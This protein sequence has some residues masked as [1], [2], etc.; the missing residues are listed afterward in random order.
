MVADIKFLFYKEIKQNIQK[1]KI[2]IFLR[3]VA[4]IFLTFLL[5]L[6][7][8]ASIL[9]ILN[10]ILDKIYT[11]TSTKTAEHTYI[12]IIYSIVVPIIWTT[13]LLKLI[14]LSKIIK[15]FKKNFF[16]SLLAFKNLL[17]IK[18]LNPKKCVQ[19]N[20]L[21][22]FIIE[23]MFEQK[24]AL[25]G[26]ASILHK[27][28]FF[29]RKPNDLDFMSVDA[30]NQKINFEFKEFELEKFKVNRILDSN[31]YYKTN[32]ED[33]SIEV[34]RPKVV[35][36]K[37]F[38]IKNKILVPNY[39]WMIAMKCEQL[40]LLLHLNAE[41]TKIYNTIFDLA[42][43]LNL[44]KKIDFN[45]LE[46]AF[47]CNKIDNY[48]VQYHLN[49]TQYHLENKEFKAKLND[50]IKNKIPELFIENQLSDLIAKTQQLIN[51]IIENPKIL[52]LCNKTYELTCNEKT[53]EAL[54]NDYFKS[55]TSQNKSLI[56]LKLEVANKNEKQN[57][58]K[59]IQTRKQDY[60]NLL[61]NFECLN[62]VYDK[63]NEIDIR[64]LLL[65]KL[66]DIL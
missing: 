55:S 11:G 28:N 37:F 5:I 18:F 40:F 66:I 22:E 24:L 17:K 48:F 33:V 38:E 7:T 51:F 36:N 16:K 46:E 58:V 43:L 56:N 6:T 63:Y 35:V 50:F 2:F 49:R 41:E 52:N 34:L 45:I 13:N 53:K 19:Y 10:N 8:T 62:P 26:S 30:S 59:K 12:L 44:K 9:V 57:F 25:Q 14:F 20:L 65:N 47:L 54:T 42:Y 29:Y 4:A 60:L 32:V 15:N 61:T 3:I 1:W 23:K 39:Y 27:Y 21:K 31:I 64:Y